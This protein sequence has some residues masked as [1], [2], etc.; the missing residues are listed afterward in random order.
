MKKK[1]RVIAICFIFLVKISFSEVNKDSLLT[2]ISSSNVDTSKVKAL[3]QLSDCYGDSN[4]N[5]AIEYLHKAYL[6]SKKINNKKCIAD[7]ANQ[8]GNNYYY[9]GDYDNAIRNFLE[10]LTAFES[11]NNLEE[12]ANCYNNIGSVYAEQQNYKKALEYHFKALK[13][14]E[15]NV[16]NGIGD[17]NDIA[18]SYGNIGQAYYYLNDYTNAMDYYNRSMVIS[19]KT[20]NTKRIALML[21]NIGSIYAEEKKY[22]E[23][24]SN[25]TKALKIQKKNENKRSIAMAFNNIAEVYLMKK[26]IKNAINFYNQG[27]EN[28]LIVSDLDDIKNSYDG[29]HNCYLSLNDF[30]NAHNYL[31]LYYSIKDSIYNSESTAQINEMLSNFELTKKEEDFLLKQKDD[32]VNKF[33]SISITVGFFLILIIL[34]LVFNKY[35]GKKT[36][37]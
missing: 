29:L 34:L 19:E 17:E 15:K 1:I 16:A 7:V 26:A 27:L 23:A 18:M 36:P 3:L 28:A 30:K 20:G 6:I 24:L 31:E 33:W 11:I 13:L 25:F 5:K 37:H 21:N 32:E 10:T 4:P 14:K 2:I 9:L 35:K 22:D 8:L 12:V